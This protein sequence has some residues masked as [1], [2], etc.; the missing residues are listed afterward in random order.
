MIVQNCIILGVEGE[1]CQKRTPTFNI[2]MEYI[3]P[4]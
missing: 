4:W 1:K 2:D 3:I